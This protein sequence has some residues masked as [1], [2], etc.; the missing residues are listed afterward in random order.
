[1]DSP[2]PSPNSPTPSPGSLPSRSR[3]DA[4]LDV[5]QEI[6]ATLSRQPGLKALQGIPLPQ[7]AEALAELHPRIGFVLGGLSSIDPAVLPPDTSLD[8]LG[9][10]LRERSVREAQDRVRF[11]GNLLQRLIFLVRNADLRERVV[12]DRAALLPYL[13]GDTADYAD[14]LSLL[15]PYEA[16]CR[17]MEMDA[18]DPRYEALADSCVQHWK[19]GRFSML[20]DALRAAT[21]TASSDAQ[22]PH[23][24]ASASETFVDAPAPATRAAALRMAFEPDP[25]AS[26]EVQPEAQPE[27]Q[28]EEAAT[29]LV[30]VLQPEA[31]TA[32]EP[33]PEPEPLPEIARSPAPAPASVAPAE[34]AA[35][36]VSE[37]AAETETESEPIPNETT[38]APSSPLLR[39]AARLDNGPN[40]PF[41]RMLGGAPAKPRIDDPTIEVDDEALKTL[42]EQF[43]NWDGK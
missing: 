28:P 27:A 41:A 31:A 5:V 9:G 35:E 14:A 37:P 3:I 23:A 42:M 1:M 39:P 26:I 17:L 24:I 6:E 34:T 2:H 32:P 12:A 15:A 13:R 21:R 30:P 43:R 29:P 10:W 8:T 11:V 22:T 40:D 33:E 36:P 16:M 20:Q 7:L 4:L 38:A 19:A 18:E 25:E